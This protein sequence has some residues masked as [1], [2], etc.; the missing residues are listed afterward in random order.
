MLASLSRRLRRYHGGGWLD[1]NSGRFGMPRRGG[2]VTDVWMPDAMLVRSL[3][4]H[5]I[6]LFDVR[7]GEAWSA[8]DWC[9]RAREAGWRCLVDD[10]ACVRRRSARLPD[11]THD[12][13]GF[14]DV[15]SR[16]SHRPRAVIQRAARM[17]ALWLLNRYEPLAAIRFFRQARCRHERTGAMIL[18]QACAQH[19]RAA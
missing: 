6:G 7:L 11:L 9:L 4:L 16:Y 3:C 18:D 12:G 8:A 15:V 14:M 1:L 13:S 10:Q 2:Y 5:R 17:H 19:R